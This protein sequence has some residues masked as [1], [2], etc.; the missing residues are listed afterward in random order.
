MAGS[1]YSTARRQRL[2]RQILARDGYQCRIGGP[3]CAGYAET[4]HHIIP[5]SQRP[6]LFFDPANLA[7]ACKPC[8]YGGAPAL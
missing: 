2:R 3:R 4:A 6:D 7:A 1:L 8:N 5:S